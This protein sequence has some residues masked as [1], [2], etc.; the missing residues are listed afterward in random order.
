MGTAMCSMSVA[1]QRCRMACAAKRL[2]NRMATECASVEAAIGAVERLSRRTGEGAATDGGSTSCGALLPL[3]PH[4]VDGELEEKNT[5]L[6]IAVVAERLLY[7]TAAAVWL[8]SAMHYAYRLATTVYNRTTR[9]GEGVGDHVLSETR[10]DEAALSEERLNIQEL[11]EFN[12]PECYSVEQLRKKVQAG[13][14]A[15]RR[16]DDARGACSVALQLRQ[17][18][19]QDQKHALYGWPDDARG[20]CEVALKLREMAAQDPGQTSYALE[21][22]LL[23]RGGGDLLPPRPEACGEEEA[24]PRATEK[25][26]EGS[27]HVILDGMIIA[28]KH[29]KC[30]QP[31]GR[32]MR[33]AS[34][35]DDCATD[36]FGSEA[37]AEPLHLRPML[38]ATCTKR[39][40][41]GQARKQ[42]RTML[43]RVRA[44]ETA[45][46]RCAARCTRQLFVDSYADKMLAYMECGGSVHAPFALSFTAHMV[47]VHQA[48]AAAATG[49][50]SGGSGGPIERQHDVL[51]KREAASPPVYGVDD[52]ACWVRY[53]PAIRMRG[54]GG[55][56]SFVQMAMAD[57]HAA[58]ERDRCVDIEASWAELV[59][60]V[61]SLPNGKRLAPSFRSV[62]YEDLMRAAWDAVQAE[63]AHRPC[64]EPPATRREPK[65]CELLCLAIM[66]MRTPPE[67]RSLLVAHSTE[68]DWWATHLNRRERARKRGDRYFCDDLT[69]ELYDVAPD[70]ADAAHVDAWVGFV[71]G[72]GLGDAAREQAVRTIR[73]RVVPF[74]ILQRP[75]ISPHGPAVHMYMWGPIG[76]LAGHGLVMKQLEFLSHRARAELSTGMDYDAQQMGEQLNP[77]VVADWPWQLPTVDSSRERFDEMLPGHLRAMERAKQR[78]GALC[79][80]HM[81]A[82]ELQRVGASRSAAVARF[83]RQW[84]ITAERPP[85]QQ[86]PSS[87]AV[88]S[89]PVK[90]EQLIE[91]EECVAARLDDIFEAI[92][93]CRALEGLCGGEDLEF[94]APEAGHERDPGSAALPPKPYPCDAMGLSAALQAVHS[95]THDSPLRPDAASDVDAAAAPDGRTA[96][97]GLFTSAQRW[98]HRHVPYKRSFGDRGRDG[99]DSCR[100]CCDSAL[101]KKQYDQIL[102]FYEESTLQMLSRLVEPGA[103]DALKHARIQE[104]CGDGVQARLVIRQLRVCGAIRHAVQQGADLGREELQVCK[105]SDDMQWV[106]YRAVREADEAACELVRTEAIYEMLHQSY[107]PCFGAGLQVEW[108]AAVCCAGEGANS[109]VEGESAKPLAYVKGGGAVLRGR[110]V[111]MERASAEVAAV[112]AVGAVSVAASAAV[113]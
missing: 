88:H 72:L 50:A 36:L 13:L 60:V 64:G 40:F 68:V 70:A 78:L 59:P 31:S 1:L 2:C 53:R 106:E 77:S 112:C 29:W 76:G 9:S 109:G 85:P 69:F 63:S 4:L 10:A 74:G 25:P 93:T 96:I 5:A 61:Q 108:V 18:A 92:S 30:L 46:Q 82:Q 57:V 65:R 56:D 83:E 80:A 47:R 55:Y 33:G 98:M 51:A 91:N 16:S 102:D 8:P 35:V 110:Y 81:R 99:R 94:G 43:A 95:Y 7:D 14:G 41:V 3:V 87:E 49:A 54:G 84:R 89:L 48:A 12:S 71:C 11:V 103:S 39:E 44:Q 27:P 23:E 104:Q 62:V 100:R 86:Q 45:V 58:A 6:A 66:W 75:P 17:V 113:S 90:L 15:I 37:L 24:D 26:L 20:T 97:N 101:H 34:A 21:R 38:L 107:W 28:W 32:P 79:D 42:L 73:R 19:A 22:C 111:P 67:A 52:F 105:L